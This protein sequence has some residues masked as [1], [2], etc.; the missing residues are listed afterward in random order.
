MLTKKKILRLENSP[1]PPPSLSSLIREA[2]RFRGWLG[3]RSLGR[4]AFKT[5][6]KIQVFSKFE[7]PFSLRVFMLSGEPSFPFRVRDPCI[8]R[9]RLCVTHSSQAQDQVHHFRCL[10]IPEYKT[11]KGWIP[12]LIKTIHTPN[13]GSGQCTICVE[14]WDKLLCI[15]FQ[16]CSFDTSLTGL[17][18]TFP[19]GDREDRSGTRGVQYCVRVICVSKFVVI[20]CG[21]RFLAVG[22]FYKR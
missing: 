17:P 6:R 3:K 10:S 16:D 11:N 9:R 19:R 7:L 22:S 15:A 4:V 18:V 14:V 1:P 8:E 21:R 5:F 13:K 2:L 12:F 20:A